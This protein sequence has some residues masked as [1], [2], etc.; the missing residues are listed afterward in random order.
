MGLGT[1]HQGYASS[2][3]DSPLL[4][5]EPVHQSPS[6][7]IYNS[8]LLITEVLTLHLLRRDEKV[9]HILS[10]PCLYMQE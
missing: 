3:P 6:D 7:I 5:H 9:D 8:R 2:A 4:L 10:V 1:V